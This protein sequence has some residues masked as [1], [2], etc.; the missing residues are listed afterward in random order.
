[1]TYE[2]RLLAVVPTAEQAQQNVFFRAEA[3]PAPGQGLP[4]GW[5]STISE[6]GPTPHLALAGL[7]YEISRLREKL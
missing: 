1:M 2:I 3:A 7:Q 6:D 4:A 5:P